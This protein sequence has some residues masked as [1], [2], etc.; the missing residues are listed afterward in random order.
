MGELDQVRTQK[1][2]TSIRNG[3]GL[4]FH[5]VLFKVRLPH[6]QI[7]R[8]GYL[9]HLNQYQ[10]RYRYLKFGSGTQRYFFRYFTSTYFSVCYKKIYFSCKNNSKPID[11]IYSEHSVIYSEYFTLTEIK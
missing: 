10:H 6:L 4:F 11:P 2:T 7:C 1:P 5:N 9:S 8:V 3:R